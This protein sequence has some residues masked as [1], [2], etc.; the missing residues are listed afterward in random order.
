MEAKAGAKDKA[1]DALKESMRQGF[2]MKTVDA[3]L[4]ELARE[5]ERAAMTAPDKKG[6][7]KL[8]PPPREVTLFQIDASGELEAGPPA[9]D[10][11]PDFIKL[12]F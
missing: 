7:A 4:T 6:G 2:K 8:A 10:P 1:K 11:P 5:V 12:K 3:S 9:K